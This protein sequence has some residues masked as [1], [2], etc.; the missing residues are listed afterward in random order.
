MIRSVTQQDA[1][2]IAK[3]YNEYVLNSTITFET[4]PVTVEEMEKRIYLLSKDFPYFV[5]EENNEIL[6][7]CYV[8]H[9]K[10]KAAYKYTLETTVYLSPNAKGKGIGT[11]LM[12][13]LIDICKEQGYHNLIACITSGNEASFKL[14]TKL[15]FKKVSHFH[16]V[17]LKFNQ[18]LDVIDYELILS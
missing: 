13:K 4:E 15:G 9:W 2:S 12:T 14:H 17:G 3:I 8:H 18:W 7:Y 1:A 11:L 16:E 10:E 5:Y 6:G